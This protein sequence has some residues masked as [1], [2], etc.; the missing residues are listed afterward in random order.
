MNYEITINVHVP[1]DLLSVINCLRASTPAEQEDDAP[2]PVEPQPVAGPP[3][4][5]PEQNLDVAKELAKKLMQ[6]QGRDAL[7]AVL[8]AH[9]L[10][11]LSGAS[12]AD[13]PKLIESLTEAVA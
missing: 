13:L 8:D 9:G 4:A 3:A 6:Q 2:R 10:E 11:K 7:K 5:A 1:D 12:E